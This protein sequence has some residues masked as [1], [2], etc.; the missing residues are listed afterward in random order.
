ML[1]RSGRK[2][3]NPL[4]FG[5]LAVGEDCQCSNG[6][7]CQSGANSQVTAAYD[8]VADSNRNNTMMSDDTVHEFPRTTFGFYYALK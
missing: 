4:T 3:K 1:D 5:Y 8:D 6:W 7:H 2:I